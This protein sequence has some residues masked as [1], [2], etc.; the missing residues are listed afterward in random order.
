MPFVPAEAQWIESLRHPVLMD[1][2]KA[3]GELQWRPRHDAHQTLVS[4]VEAARLARL[5]R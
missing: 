1:T 4:M 2:A 3:R 5:V